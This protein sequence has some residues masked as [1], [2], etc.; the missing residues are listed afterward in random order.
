[1]FFTGFPRNASDIAAEQ[2]KNTPK[3]TFELNTMVSLANEAKRVLYSN[4]NLDEFGN[5]LDQSWQIKKGLSSKITTSFIDEAYGIA[6][7]AGAI[8]GK[9]L[10]AGGG[11][12]MIFF[13]HPEKHVKIIHKL[14]HMLHV[15]FKFENTGSQIIYRGSNKNKI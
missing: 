13:A 1:M 6:R 5:L 2:I 14:K 3:K 7:S 4:G 8:G 10:G 9:L 12:F 15:P 11:G